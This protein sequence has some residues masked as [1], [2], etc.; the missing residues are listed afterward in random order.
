M[1]KQDELKGKIAKLKVVREKMLKSGKE[2]FAKGADKTI[3]K[4]E[5]EIKELDSKAEG[6]VKKVE[7]DVKKALAPKKSKKTAKKTAKKTEKK[8]TGSMSK[9]E[10]QELID[11]MKERYKMAEARKEKNIKSGRAE[12]DG[13]LKVSASLKDEAKSLDNKQ[14]AGQD[15]NKAEQKEVIVNIEKIAKSCVEMVKTSKDS[16]M[17]IK[18][19]IKRL[20]RVLEDVE[21]GRLKYE[22]S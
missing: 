22:E 20:E 6:E 10:C 7:K 19:L 1:S 15:L 3:A 16:K 21:S 11:T 17:L 5:A 13:A 9:A 12:K 2:S 4:F 8:A 14:D 18:N